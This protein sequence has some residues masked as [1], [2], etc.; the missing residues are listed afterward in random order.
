MIRLVA[1]SKH[2]ASCCHTQHNALCTLHF[3]VCSCWMFS[4]NTLLTLIHAGFHYMLT[5]IQLVFITCLTQPDFFK[6][7]DLKHTAATLIQLLYLIRHTDNHQHTASTLS[8][9]NDVKQNDLSYSTQ[10]TLHFA[11]CCLFMLNVFIQHFAYIDTCWFSLHAYI[12]TAGFHYML[13][14]TRLL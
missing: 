6:Q 7:N 4:F 14:T 9:N 3:A 11:L 12:D 2:S 5:L 1:A 8:M 10:C 13:N